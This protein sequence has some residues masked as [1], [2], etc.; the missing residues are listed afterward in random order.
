[1]VLQ[2]QVTQIKH[3]PIIEKLLVWTFLQ[4]FFIC[5]ESNSPYKIRSDAIQT[6]WLKWCL[7]PV[8]HRCM[9]G[10]HSRKL[11]GC[12]G[13]H[14]R[15]SKYVTSGSPAMHPKDQRSNPGWT[16][17]GIS[18]PNH[19]RSSRALQEGPWPLEDILNFKDMNFKDISSFV[20]RGLMDG[21]IQFNVTVRPGLE[22]IRL[23]TISA[24]RAKP[25]FMSF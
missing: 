20:S 22:K 18:P 6:F 9:H 25:G 14:E 2:C 19:G 8:D 11:G 10:Y 17:R 13:I 16:P 12:L 24:L 4:Y 21:T 23:P 5:E 3:F 7:R 15:G 1:M